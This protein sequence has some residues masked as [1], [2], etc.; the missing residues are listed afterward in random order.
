[1][2]VLKSLGKRRQQPQSVQECQN[3][4]E[5][6]E[7]LFYTLPATAQG[8]ISSSTDVRVNKCHTVIVRLLSEKGRMFEAQEPLRAGQVTS[9]T[10]YLTPPAQFQKILVTT[11]Q[12]H[13]EAQ[14][15]YRQTVGN[16]L[17]GMVAMTILGR[18][19]VCNNTDMKIWSQAVLN[20]DLCPTTYQC[21][22]GSPGLS[23]PSTTKPLP[24]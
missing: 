7:G 19:G 9:W 4:S 23:I 10:G 11:F 20:S 2:W 3:V 1:M 17:Q 18:I 6:G 5:D 14:R 12:S 24:H 13:C 22:P 16:Q 21:D 8:F 15:W